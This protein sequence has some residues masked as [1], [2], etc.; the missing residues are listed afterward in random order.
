MK[1]WN[2][3]ELLF[4]LKKQ[5]ANVELHGEIILATME[6]HG[7]LPIL[8]SVGESQIVMKVDLYPVSA[9]VNPARINEAFLRMNDTLPMSNVSI[10]DNADG[11]AIYAL[12]GQMAA[13]TI[14]EN[15]VL[16]LDILAENAL[17]LH[18]VAKDGFINKQA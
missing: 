14:F 16:E 3:T 11:E 7:D 18:E 15:I 12:S 17:E 5:G 6:E 9:A 10:Y 8:I 2:T 1:K 4:A 13:S